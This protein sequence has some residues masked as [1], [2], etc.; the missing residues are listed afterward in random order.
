MMPEFLRRDNITGENELKRLL[1]EYIKRFG[2]GIDTEPI[3]M[4]DEEMIDLLKYCISQ[5]VSYE[6]IFGKTEY[7]DDTDY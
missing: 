6:D 7:D 5:N 2:S 1:D 4:S 3:Q